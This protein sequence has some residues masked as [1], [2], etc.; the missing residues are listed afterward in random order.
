MLQ[1][2]NAS[3]T[4]TDDQIEAA[5][6]AFEGMR[7]ESSLGAR[8]T[9]DVLNA[10]QD[11]LDAETSKAQAVNNR[12]VAAYGLLAAMGKLTAQNL[13]LGVVTYDPAAY[14]ESVKSAPKISDRGAQLDKVLK[15][16]GKTE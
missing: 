9:L 8:T 7:E 10:E 1:V 11:L 4:A 3:L 14:Y 12:Y 5:K 6:L 13:N 2:S 16:L 15:S